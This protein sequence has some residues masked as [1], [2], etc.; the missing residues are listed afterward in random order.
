MAVNREILEATRQSPEYEKGLAA[1]GNPDDYATQVMLEFV[2]YFFLMTIQH[3][4]NLEGLEDFLRQMG[5]TPIRNGENY[6][7]ESEDEEG[8]VTVFTYIVG[9]TS[10]DYFQD[11]LKLRAQLSES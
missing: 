8:L 11:F 2:G 9:R 1:L 6:S 3:K 5:I 4:G 10:M 7:F